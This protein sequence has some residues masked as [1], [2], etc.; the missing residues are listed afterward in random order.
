MTDFSLDSARETIAIFDQNIAI[1]ENETR[2][3]VERLHNA[4]LS[5]D[6]QQ[7]KKAWDRCA[8]ETRPLRAA[9]EQLVKAVATIVG[10][11]APAPGVINQQKVEP[12]K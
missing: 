8:E 12:S 4:G 7:I 1:A 5:F 3:I 6:S 11:T 10:M 2:Q 9:R